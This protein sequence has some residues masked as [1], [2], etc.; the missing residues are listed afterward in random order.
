MSKKTTIVTLTAALLIITGAT[1][2]DRVF[3]SNGDN[4]SSRRGVQAK[5]MSRDKGRAG[6]VE[7]ISGNIINI[8]TKKGEV[9]AVDSTNAKLYKAKDVEMNLSDI[10]MGDKI[11][12]LG[13]IIDHSISATEIFD[14]KKVRM[15]A[16]KFGKKFQGVVGI[17]TSISGDSITLTSKDN[18]VYVVDA[19]NAGVKKGPNDSDVS[20][21]KSGDR[22]FVRGVVTG[23]TVVAIDIRDGL[24]KRGSNEK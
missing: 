1:F 3:A 11:F 5:H 14:G 21:I 18:T 13:S 22:L 19:S 20:Q 9:F 12:A 10:K 15:R 4:G 7:S 17:V 6:T 8:K 24:G 16:A 2:T 23:T